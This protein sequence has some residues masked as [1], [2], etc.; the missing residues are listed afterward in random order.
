MVRSVLKS[1]NDRSEPGP[2]FKSS[3]WRAKVCNQIAIV[4]LGI[5][6][7]WPYVVFISFKWPSSLSH[8]NLNILK[9]HRIQCRINYIHL[10]LIKPLVSSIFIWSSINTKFT[11]F[12]NLSRLSAEFNCI[13]LLQKQGIYT[14][15]CTAFLVV[16]GKETITIPWQSGFT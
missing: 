7:A 3:S 6:N 15:Q 4:S 16:F 8:H 14:S 13:F 5:L 9:S 2:G 1:P 12:V 10:Q 11:H